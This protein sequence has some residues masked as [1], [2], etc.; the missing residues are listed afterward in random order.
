MKESLQETFADASAISFKNM[1]ESQTRLGSMRKF[2]RARPTEGLYCVVLYGV[3]GS[4]VNDCPYGEC[5]IMM[6]AFFS[7]QTIS[8]KI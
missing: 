8:S 1:T 4:L 5:P 3:R 2:S 6:S 7:G